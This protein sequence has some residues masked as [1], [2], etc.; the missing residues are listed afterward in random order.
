MATSGDFSMATD[1][2]QGCACG[3]TLTLARDEMAQLRQ[4]DLFGTTAWR[5]SYGRRSAVESVNA[6]VSEHHAHLRRGSTRV[7]GTYRTG[8]LLAF[9][10]AAV[11]IRVLIARYGYD[12][13]NPP[14]EGT[15]ITP[16][17]SKSKALHRTLP[18]KRRQRRTQS[19][20]PGSGPPTTEARWTSPLAP[21]EHMTHTD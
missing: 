11:N 21:A 13:G 1:N 4:S 15:E 12:I 14:P 19:R 20:P 18:F 5:A 8:I 9:I 7:R 6:S 17:P 16:L 3:R 2:G 10:L